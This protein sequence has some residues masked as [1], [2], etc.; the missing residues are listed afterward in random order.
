MEDIIKYFSELFMLKRQK[1]AGFK[2]A[3]VSEL[4]CDSLGEHE[5]VTAKIAYV[6]GKMEGTDAEKCAL[7]A[8]FHDDGETRVGDQ[9][10]VSARYF[11]IGEAEMEALKGQVSNLPGDLGERIVNLVQQK[12]TRNTREGIIVQD[13]D[14][15]EVALQA[16]ILVEQ[17]Y[18]GCEDW[19][20][21]VQAALETESAKKILSEIRQM[22]DFTNCWWEGLKKMTYKKLS[23]KD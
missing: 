6:L 21:N 23:E 1:R 11:R 3:G 12:E 16:K 14:W 18:K 20:N 9:N 10:K 22:K 5:A 4:L 17:G 7:I 13:A 15:L 8:L 2:L 19:I